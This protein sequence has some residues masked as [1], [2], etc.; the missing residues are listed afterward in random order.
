MHHQ[1]FLTNFAFLDEKSF[2]GLT[3]SCDDSEEERLS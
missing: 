3:P 1:S 2:K